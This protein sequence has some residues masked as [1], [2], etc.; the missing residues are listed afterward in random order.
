MIRAILS[1]SAPPKQVGTAITAIA[2]VQALAT[3]VYPAVWGSFYKALAT[4]RLVF[5][6]RS[7]V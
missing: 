1:K 4:T 6:E 3:I 5:T 2:S 7:D